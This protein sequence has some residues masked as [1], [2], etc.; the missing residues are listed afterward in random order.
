M[1]YKKYN[2]F[3]FLPL[4]LI[5]CYFLP[6]FI[7]GENSKIRIHDNLDSNL[8]WVK[9]LLEKT[10]FFPAPNTIFNN[11]MD[12][13]SL[14]SLY[15]YYNLPVLF[16]SIFGMYWGYIFNRLLMSIL[17]YIGMFYLLDNHFLKSKYRCNEISS[18][19]A[20]LFSVLPFWSFDLSVS[21][22]PL[23]LFSIINLKKDSSNIFLNYFILVLYGFYSSFILV[24]FFIII[25]LLISGFIDFL[26][27][28][29]LNK[30][31]ILGLLLLLL[32][33]FISHYP[34]FYQF[35]FEKEF[36]SHRVNAQILP[37]SLLE[38]LNESYLLLTEGQIHTWSLQKFLIIPICIFPLIFKST[39]TKLPFYYFYIL[40]FILLTSLFYGL[41]NYEGVNEFF[42]LVYTKIPFDFRRWYFLHPLMWYLLTAISISILYRDKYKYL[43]LFLFFLQLC[44]AVRY[45]SFVLY[46]TDPSFKEF[47]ATNLFQNIKDEINLK[48]DG[49]NVKVLSVGIHPSIVQFNGIETLDG[50]FPNY[51]LSYKLKFKKIISEEIKK[52]STLE[53]YFNNWGSRCYAFS[54]EQK[55]DFLNNNPNK[56]EK[57]SFNYN[58]LKEMDCSYIFSTSEINLDKNKKLELIN[59]LGGK[60]NYWLINIYKIK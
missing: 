24:G 44:Y 13:I 1:S 42:N 30:Q 49:R 15:P 18:I 14:S 50:Y 56:I 28:K 48:Q 25:I 58:L 36:I 47:Y 9:L 45:H 52:D 40:F 32:S 17:A 20:L 39:R 43:F 5:F 6:F 19:V 2:F 10:S 60:Q 59:A 23:L 55:R 27:L 46:R 26:R 35:L 51:S 3:K 16:F 54:S 22:L 8:V 33:Y 21:G 7:F 37:L 4:I 11:V 53:K 31:F 12:G 38:S 57:L 41:W 29:K 34:L